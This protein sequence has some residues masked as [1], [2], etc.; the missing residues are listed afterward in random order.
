MR[1]ETCTRCIR[2]QLTGWIRTHVWAYGLECVL[3]RGG[4]LAW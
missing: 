2:G 1:L 4:W 3:Y